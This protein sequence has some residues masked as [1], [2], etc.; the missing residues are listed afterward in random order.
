M[1]GQCRVV[2][3]K[4]K[5]VQGERCRGDEQEEEEEDDERAVLH[6]AGVLLG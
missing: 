1:G 4:K 3:M 6:R 2:T 5:T